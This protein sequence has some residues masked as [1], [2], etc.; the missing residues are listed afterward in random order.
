M[1]T[2]TIFNRLKLHKNCISAYV[3]FKYAHLAILPKTKAKQL[4]L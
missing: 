3:W 2:F 1:T 4:T